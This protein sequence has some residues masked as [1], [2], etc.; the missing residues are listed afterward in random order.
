MKLLERD[1]TCFGSDDLK[2]LL[3]VR[4]D[5]PQ[6]SETHKRKEV[7]AHAPWS[8]IMLLTALG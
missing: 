3:E 7:E 6:T 5:D 4:P 2:K 8:V 1:S